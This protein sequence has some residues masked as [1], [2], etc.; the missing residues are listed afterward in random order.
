MFLALLFHYRAKAYEM[1]GNTAAACQY[2]TRACLSKTRHGA[3][4]PRDVSQ[5]WMRVAAMQHSDA[6]ALQKMKLDWSL[7]VPGVCLA[8][9]CGGNT[10]GHSN[11]VKRSAKHANTFE[12]E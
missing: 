1:L 8:L 10:P 4:V 12:P 7:A 9:W 5:E 2:L 3:P 11:A 6:P